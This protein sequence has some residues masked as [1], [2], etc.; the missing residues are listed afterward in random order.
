MVVAK[1]P[2]GLMPDLTVAAMPVR[3]LERSVKVLRRKK[4]PLLRVLWE[5]EGLEEVTW[6]PE[7]KMKLHFRKWFD[8]QAEA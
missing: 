2:E 5:C 4:I 6:E 7:A 3:I 8:K 1:I